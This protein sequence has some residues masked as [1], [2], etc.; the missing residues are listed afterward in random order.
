MSTLVQ[1][2]IKA[3][4]FCRTEND[5]LTHKSSLNP[6]VDLF[7]KIGCKDFEDLFINIEDALLNSKDHTLRILLWSRDILE[8]AGLR[9]NFRGGL[10]YLLKMRHITPQEFVNLF[11]FAID[12][13]IAYWKD[14]ILIYPYLSVEI[15]KVVINIIT[16]SLVA[17]ADNLLFKW[18]PRKGLLFNHLSKE[19]EINVKSLRKFLVENSST[20]EQQISAEKYSEID[21]S[22]VPSIAS[23][24]YARLFNRKDAT[25]Y[26]EYIKNVKTGT[27][28]M[29]A[30]AIWP[31]EII[32]EGVEKIFYP[33]RYKNEDINWDQ[34]DAQWK[35]LPNFLKDAPP[36][37]Y[38][39]IIDNSG[40]MIYSSPLP[41][42]VAC[43]LGIYISERNVGRFH[44]EFV[45]F[46]G[47][48]QFHKFQDE[49][50]LRHK[51]EKMFQYAEVSNTNIERTFQVLLD[52]AKTSD[53]PSDEMPKCL[54]I[55]S[56]MQ[57]D[58]CVA[59]YDE[60]MFFMVRRMYHKASYE[61]PKIVFWS[62]RNATGVP[63]TFDQFGTAL[64]SGY[65]PSI[66]KSI[67]S[68]EELTPYNVMIS[69]IMNERYNYKERDEK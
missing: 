10:L 34:M 2:A 23:K 16:W 17:K 35:C 44:N 61:L 39:P 55:I 60:S 41:M 9:Q 18:L 45:S 38:L 62:V 57:F 33:G 42:Q 47:N 4:N 13:G 30:S 54:L 46:S 50:G 68:A 25:R 3:T 29:H 65:S 8:G 48:P 49:S 40:S 53:V 1:E 15:R 32:R 66:M 36:N 20:V 19:L 37:Y 21:Y 63:V 5:M 6:T 59:D 28:K 64:V 69:T 11:I 24:R 26:G 14:L 56:D 52:V 12:F 51:L 43:A 31:H 7:F 27:E 22:Q 58:N 67:I